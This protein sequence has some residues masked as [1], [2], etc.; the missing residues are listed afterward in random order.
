MKPISIFLLSSLLFAS[1]VSVAFA[2]RLSAPKVAPLQTWR[3]LRAPHHIW[4]YGDAIYYSFKLDDGSNGHLVVVNMKT[5]KWEFRPALADAT[6]A[7]TS[8]IAIKNTASAAVNGGY[9]N[10]KDAGQSTSFVTV[11]GA[12]VADPRANKLLTENPKLIP[13]LPQIYNRTEVRFL[14][15]GRGKS[16][17]QIAKHNDPLPAGAT[18]VHSL[19]GGPRLLPSIT[20][21]EEAFVRTDPEGTTDAINTRKPAARTAFG[22]TPDGYAMLLTVSGK[23]QDPESSGVSLSQLAEALKKLGCT[24]AVNFDGGA[25]TTMF[26]RLGTPGT[27]ASSKDAPPPGAVVCGKNPET[28]VKSVLLLVPS[29]GRR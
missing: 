12:M 25:S 11:D 13:Y 28:R 7:P 29:A 23:G 22:I 16:L 9:F 20:A 18:L 15:N 26:V 4:P 6:T 24:E 14:K 17:I 3:E 10:L 8:E 21:S 27:P 5:G 1:A 2:A 19:Q